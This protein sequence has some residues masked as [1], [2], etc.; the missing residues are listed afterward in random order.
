MKFRNYQVKIES[1]LTIRLINKQNQK[2]LRLSIISGILKKK[3][4]ER[5]RNIQLGVRFLQ[6]E[7]KQKLQR[8]SRR[9]MKKDERIIIQIH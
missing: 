2:I 7:R 8:K 6:K 1:Y 4:K 5:S 3:I 9:T